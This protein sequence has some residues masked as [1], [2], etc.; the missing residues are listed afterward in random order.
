LPVK[1]KSKS[2]TPLFAK[3]KHIPDM[4]PENDAKEMAKTSCVWLPA[5]R[6]RSGVRSLA[7]ELSM[8]LEM[9]GVV[10]E[11][12]VG[13]GMF[14]EEGERSAEEESDELDLSVRREKENSVICV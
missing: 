10:S 5:L 4:M 1:V 13:R 14:I 11:V 9:T 6:S 7:S 8:V 2:S 3:S 12:C